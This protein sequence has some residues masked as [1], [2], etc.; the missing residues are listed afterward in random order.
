M[1]ENISN[2]RCEWVP[3]PVLD[4]TRSSLI[5]RRAPNCSCPLSWYL[6][7]V[8]SEYYK[9]ILRSP[10]V[11]CEGEGMECLQP[12]V[13]G[14]PPVGGK[15]GYNLQRRHGSSLQWYRAK[16]RGGKGYRESSKA[17]LCG[18]E[19]KIQFENW[20]GGFRHRLG[21]YI[22]FATEQSSRFQRAR[23]Q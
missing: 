15:A 20:W 7:R 14:T 13:I 18:S 5:T 6:C 9:I 16:C 19:E 17:G 1:Y 12:T 8:I 2:S 22:P 21:S 3:N 23:W 10:Y 4:A 11:R